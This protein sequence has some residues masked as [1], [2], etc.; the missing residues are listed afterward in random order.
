M[1]SHE[2]PRPRVTNVPVLYL[3]FDGCLHPQEV[4]QQRGGE[5]YVREPLGHRTFE[6]AALL[7]GLLR[8][9]PDVRIVLSTTWT[10]HHGYLGAA[11]HLPTP[12]RRRCVGAVWHHAMDRHEFD[13][14]ER[15]QQVLEDVESRHPTTWLAI[16]DDARGW[17]DALETNLVVTHPVL[18]IAEPTVL[19]RLRTALERFDE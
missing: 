15:G 7:E 12:L 2:L 14:L 16:D 13:Q 5:P 8:P 11:A 17:G 19:E 10:R 1:R 4:W 3:D 6:H 9:Y 18:G